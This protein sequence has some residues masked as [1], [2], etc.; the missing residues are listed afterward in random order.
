MVTDDQGNTYRQT[1]ISKWYIYRQHKRWKFE[2][3]TTRQLSRLC[4]FRNP[5]FMQHKI[6]EDQIPVSGFADL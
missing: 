3:S 5:L 4:N 2:W 6:D 1:V